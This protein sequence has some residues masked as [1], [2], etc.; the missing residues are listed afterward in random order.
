MSSRVQEDRQV[1]TEKIIQGLKKDGLNWIRDWGLLE[2]PRNAINKETKYRG[3]NKVNLQIAMLEKG[4]KDPRWVTFIQAKNEG[5]K[6]KSGEK[7]IKCEYWQFS[8]TEKIK[9]EK[10]NIKE[11]ETKL[12][13]PRRSTFNL[14]N[15]E[16]LEGIEPYQFKDGLNIEKYPEIITQ[17]ENTSPCNIEY[18]NQ[19]EAF[20]APGKDVIVMPL[21]ESFYSEEGLLATL[22]HEISHSTGHPD[23]LARKF[24]KSDEAYAREELIAEI[25]TVFIQNE[26]GIKLSENHFNNHTAYIQS[27][28]KTLKDNA[29]EIYTI[30][31]EA[32]KISEYVVERYNERE[33]LNKNI[34]KE[35]LFKNLKINLISSEYDFKIPEGTTLRGEEAYNFLNKLSEVDKE[36]YEKKL[37]TYK[38]SLDVSY[39]NFSQSER[40]YVG[41]GFFKDNEYVSDGLKE[42]LKQPAKDLINDIEWHKKRLNLSEE[43]ITKYAN[44]E[45]QKIDLICDLIK[46]EE[47]SKKREGQ[48]PIKENQGMER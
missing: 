27:W 7:S 42:L 38:V 44:K 36:K 8:K 32:E 46:I 28:L 23:R 1:L 15:A 29:N 48:S 14:F 20:Y 26:I 11:I 31:T 25:A 30:A 9:D 41:E 13:M 43:E 17:L 6:V 19:N 16:Q 34:E 45:I 35:E 12:S 39:N 2:V 21:K 33:L 10:G 37:P 22:I 24:G 40:I 4:Y 18:K 3:A 5:W 47:I